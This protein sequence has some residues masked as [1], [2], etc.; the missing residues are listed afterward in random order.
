MIPVFSQVLTKK[1]FVKAVQIADG[2]YYF[3]EDFEKA[4]S[5]YE[6]LIK[7]NPENL[8]LSAKL[9]I[10]YLNIDGKK[11]DA[12]KLLTKASA[13]VVRNDNEYIEF[14]EKAP[15]D[16][17]L[18]LAIAYHQNDSLQ[19]A[20]ELYTRA[21][22]K[23][24]GSKLFRVDYINNQIK[25][26]G[27]AMEMEKKPVIITEN[28][29]TPW[30][31]EY[32]GAMN[33]VVSGNDS[34]FV[35]TQK[36]DGK[37]RIL[38]SYKKD[39]WRKPVD[40]T[41]QLGK[42]DGFYSNSITGD[43]KILIIYINDG[44][45]GNLYYSIRKD[46]TW[47]KVKSLGKCINTIYW[48]SHGFITPD[49]KT[50]YFTS[51]RPDGAGEL[52]IWTSDK[53][54]KDEWKQPVNCGRVIN[55]PYNETTPFYDPSTN[56][57]LY[58]SEGL[59]GM[60]SYDVFKSIKKNGKWT[61]PLGLPYAINNTTENTFFAS[62]NNF[63][64]YLTSLYKEK[65]GERNIYSLVEAD[66]TDQ[67]MRADGNLTL[68][69]GIAVDPGLT[70][71]QLFDQ[72]TGSLLK[73]ISLTDSASF[74]YV[75]KP[76]KF[77]IIISRIGDK[78][79]TINLN[80]KKEKQ[81][82]YKSL[83]DTASFK[84]EV[85]PGDYQ[86][87]INHTGYKT[88]TINLSI[89]SRFPGNYISVNSSLIPNK[90]FSGDFLAIKNLLFDYDSYL[91]TDKALTVL[92]GLRAIL[93]KYQELK[94]EVA[95][96]TDSM[97]STEYNLNLADKRAQTII[98]YFTTSGISET[99]FVKKAFGSSDFVALNTYKDGSDNP[100]G[101]KYNRRVTF[102]IINPQTGVIIHMDNFIPEQLRQP[103]SAKYSIVL[104]KT[105]N[106]VTP[107]KFSLITLKELH[108]VRAINTDSMN[109][110]LIGVFYDIDE[111]SK[112]LVFAKGKGFKDAYIIKQNEI[113][114]LS[115]SIINQESIQIQPEL[116][117]IYTIQLA[118]SKKR[119]NMNQ[120]KMIEGVK[121]LFSDDGY[122]RYVYGEYSSVIEARAGL[123]SVKDSGFKEAFV[124]VLPSS[125]RK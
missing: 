2:F 53:D 50:F 67:I 31:I 63:H 26:C 27:Y 119:L 35:F 98:N 15:L 54:A 28:L 125:V 36:K 113:S 6:P 104:L 81:P 110:Y 65:T 122:Y 19:K 78:T 88:D 77:K 52:D 22:K 76:G 66:T 8:N 111:A 43:G 24:S 72:K 30:L 10:C 106:D 57:L 11:S 107:D 103:Y 95:G 121:E 116:K 86:L 85:K 4:A 33:P 41:R 105:N 102:G 60:G 49:G 108:L 44:G 70:R 69:D 117:K 120:F 58:S 1:Q 37:T 18:Y 64:G 87:F 118:A 74:N 114:G 34:T 83:I 42:N 97:G 39:N 55:T 89:P 75:M 12:L 51:N 5:L 62:G 109:L 61:K 112:Y 71:I 94:I 79:D 23:L 101:R 59:T 45:D 82:D 93:I 7:S 123:G 92:E 32:P 56:S 9:G 29:F 40:I 48:E 47:S 17:Y 80:V 21:K 91:I 13:N 90:V 100:E 99:R 124:K 73:N 25:N 16:T 46:T 20:I 96:Y 115:K 14:G 84:F 3:D 38:C 68:Q